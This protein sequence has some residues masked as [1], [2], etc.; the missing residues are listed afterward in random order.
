MLNFCKCSVIV[1]QNCYLTVKET[2]SSRWI[3]CCPCCRHDQD[4]SFISLPS[5]LRV[6]FHRQDDCYIRNHKLTKTVGDRFILNTRAFWDKNA[7]GVCRDIDTANSF[8]RDQLSRFE[9]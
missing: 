1:C 8:V 9:C 3:Y 5:R 2:A 4:L 7:A 6:C